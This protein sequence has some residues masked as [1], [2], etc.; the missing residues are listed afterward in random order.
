MGVVEKSGGAMTV[1]AF[2]VIPANAEI[3]LVR[4]RR[5]DKRDPPGVTNLCSNK[6][7]CW[8]CCTCSVTVIASVPRPNVIPA[9]GAASR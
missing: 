5:R 2:P 9:I 1:T 6:S 7:Y 8:T 4:Q 3:P